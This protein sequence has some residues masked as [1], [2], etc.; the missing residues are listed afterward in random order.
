MQLHNCNSST[1]TNINNGP[2]SEKVNLKLFSLY[3]AF[4][5]KSTIQCRESFCTLFLRKHAQPASHKPTT[6]AAWLNSVLLPDCSTSDQIRVKKNKEAVFGQSKSISHATS[7]TLATMPPN[8][9]EPCST[10]G[11]MRK[12]FFSS[13]L[14][15]SNTIPAYIRTWIHPE[16]S[17][18]LRTS[19]CWCLYSLNPVKPDEARILFWNQQHRIVSVFYSPN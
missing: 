11:S 13:S 14:F 19:Y 9:I 4:A 1:L 18:S 10:R 3:A 6:A 8:Q 15:T 5:T 16:R 12:Y 17:S 7:E 2:T